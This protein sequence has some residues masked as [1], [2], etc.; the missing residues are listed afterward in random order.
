MSNVQN[1]EEPEDDLPTAVPLSDQM[2]AS[3]NAKS[4]LR[5]KLRMLGALAV[6]GVVGVWFVL[7][8]GGTVETDN[9]YMLSNW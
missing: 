4:H 6:L 9:A 1:I 5:T 8:S 2:S 3:Q 7:T